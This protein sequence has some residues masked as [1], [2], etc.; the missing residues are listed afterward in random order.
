MLD[1]DLGSWNE[2]TVRAFFQQDIANEIL[3]LP[4][5]QHGGGDVACWPFTKFGEYSVR[6]AYNFTRA[7]SFM[8]SRS[9]NGRGQSS[10]SASEERNWK[11]IWS[12]TAPNKMKVVLWRLAH[13]CLPSGVQLLRRQVPTTDACCFCEWME[14]IEHCMLFC[15]YARAVWD[16]VKSSYGLTLR[17]SNFRSPRQWL[18]DFLQLSSDHAAT[19]LTVTLWHI[20]EARNDTR[21][22][23]ATPHPRCIAMKIKAYVELI[24]FHLFKPAPE[25]SREARASSAL[26]FPPPPGT[27]LLMSDAA[28]FSDQGKSGAG[29]VALDHAGRCV[30]ACCESFQGKLI[31]ELAEAKA[32]RRAIFLARE[33]NFDKVIFASDCLSLIQR[34]HSSSR[35]RSSVGSVVADIKFAS[36]VFSSVLFKFVRRHGNVVAHC[37][38]KASVNFSNLC[39]FRSAPECIW[40]ALCNLVV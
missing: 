39:V 8:V 9:Y 19:V 28:V 5:C 2:E 11:A 7:A 17:R 1:D 21:N 34:L 10:N 38:A 31:P 36:S 32:L 35:D 6:S 20:W 40:E 24:F 12:V 18:F 14:T 25:S 22:G 13:D 4:V 37:L 15:S 23:I 16:E 33:E 27:V 29:V 30:I 3:Q 26:M